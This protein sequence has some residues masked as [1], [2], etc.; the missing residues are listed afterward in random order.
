[1]SPANESFKYLGM[2]AFWHELPVFTF[3]QMSRARCPLVYR[4]PGLNT[5]IISRPMYVRTTQELC[6][7]PG[8]SGRLPS[9]R[10][11]GAC[12]RAE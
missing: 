2:N 1:M 6:S 3:N 4:G 9:A 10:T 11:T 8:R 12:T 7:R 5:N